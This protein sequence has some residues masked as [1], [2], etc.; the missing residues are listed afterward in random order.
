VSKA[1][2]EKISP[3]LDTRTDMPPQ[4]VEKISTALNVLLADTFALY[5]KTKNFHRHVSGRHFHDYHL[6]LDEQSDAIFATID[7]F[8]ERF[9]KSSRPKSR[10]PNRGTCPCTAVVDGLR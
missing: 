5:M 10:D 1:K 4:A 6:M 2:L 7:H 8:A 3:D 9:R